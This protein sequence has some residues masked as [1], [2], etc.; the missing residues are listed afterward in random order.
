MANTTSS[1][2]NNQLWGYYV[3]KALM[4]LYNETPLYDF[5]EKKELVDDR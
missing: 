4:T 3:D 1:T 5:A 2:N